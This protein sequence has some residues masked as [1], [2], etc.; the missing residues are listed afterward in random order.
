MLQWGG[1]ITLHLRVHVY[2]AASEATGALRLLPLTPIG[3]EPVRGAQSETVFYRFSTPIRVKVRM[4]ASYS[5]A[6][7]VRGASVHTEI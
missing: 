1:N 5:E 4:R 7:E 3:V 6:T 2:V